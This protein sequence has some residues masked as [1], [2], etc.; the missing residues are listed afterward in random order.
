VRIVGDAV[1][2]QDRWLPQIAL[3]ANY[4]STADIGGIPKAL[5]ASRASGYDL[6]AAATKVFLGA[7]CGRNVLVDATV[8]SSDVNQLGLLGAGG[9]VGRTWRASGTGGVWLADRVL[10][11]AEYRAKRGA[12]QAPVEGDAH[13]V[14]IA[15]A[16]S[17]H[18][19][20]VAAYVDLGPAAGQGLERGPY[21]SLSGTF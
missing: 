6:Y 21:L 5:G 19:S 9:A 20:I 8:T 16:P 17:K 13:D 12:L 10:V 18:L 1:Y 7:L 4:H 11:A 14:F 2:D 3:G 15:F